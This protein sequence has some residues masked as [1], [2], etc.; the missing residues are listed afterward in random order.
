MDTRSRAGLDLRRRTR[1][2]SEG[3]AMAFLNQQAFDDPRSFQAARGVDFRPAN[4]ITDAKGRVLF[5]AQTGGMLAPQ[6]RE[7][8]SGEILFRFG[9]RA[10]GV[11]AV[12]GGGWW[13][14]RTSFEKLF[15]FAQTWDLSIGVAMRLLCLV[16]PEWSDATLLVRARTCAPLLAWRGLAAPV[17]TPAKDGGPMVRMPN[18][19]EIAERR[20]HQLF[21]PGLAALPSSNPGLKVE[22][23]YPLD[24]EASRRGFIYL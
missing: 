21:I 12:A 23:D 10:A 2:R 4:A 7:L 20:L 19:N 3:A 6:K 16:P 1:E 15:S 18:P 14:E 8:Q 9:T 17:V 24:A 11:K 13:L 5:H 22:Q